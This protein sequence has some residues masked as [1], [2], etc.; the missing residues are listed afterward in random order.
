[1]P[2]QQP[3]N[4]VRSAILFH[5][6]EFQIGKNTV[7]T[8][9]QQGLGKDNCAVITPEE[10]IDRAKGFL[11]HQLVLIDEIKLKGQFQ[12]KISTLNT[13]KPM[14]TN[15]DFR[16]RPLFHNWKDIYSTSFFMLFTNHK[17]ALAVDENEARYTIIDVGKTREEM[18]GDEFFNLFWT[19]QGHLVEGLASAVK[20]F[21]SNRQI[22]PNFNPKSISLKTNFLKVMSKEGG[23]PLLKEIEP[24]FKER[25]TPFHQTVI[26]IQDAFDW[27]K[28]HKKI[29]GRINDLADVL[30]KLGC[31]RVG[32]IKNKRTGKHPVIWLLRN[33]DF[34]CDKKMTDICNEYWLPTDR[35]SY[36][37]IWNLSSGDIL[38]IEGRLKEIDAY[39]EFHQGK[40][41]EDP[42][43]EYETIRRKRMSA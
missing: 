3:G 32:E 30:K 17:D 25:A 15:E 38:K 22:S 18:G 41:E 9:V 13:M 27:L 16:I 43:E 7:F 31:E 8:I 28:K 42:E 14:M 29:T 6:K 37:P 10:A 23:H 1:M 19:P 12:E 33:F 24:L 20:W 40:P 11:E 5:S 21:L 2:F 39:E 26:S 4:K 34:F 35:E 36:G